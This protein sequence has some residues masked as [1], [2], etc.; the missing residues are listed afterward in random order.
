MRAR[1][2]VGTT[3]WAGRG[4]VATGWYPRDV[5]T[6]EERLHYYASQFPIVENEAG[7]YAI[8]TP[9][10]VALWADRTPD[11]F[12]MN[13][14]AHALFTAHYADPRR[15]PRDVVEALP[16]GVRAKPHV[17][18]R[19]LSVATMR[20]LER[21]FRD[22]L[23]PLHEAGK[24]GVVLFQFPMW[25]VISREHKAELSRLRESFAPYRVAV[26][27]RNKTWLSEE[28]RD[29]TLAHLRKEDIAYCCVDEVGPIPPIAAAT[30]DIA[31]VRMHGRNA[32]RF[33]GR[34]SLP[35]GARY[36]YTQAELREWVPRIRELAKHARE[37]HVL[38]NNA[39]ADYA[40]RGAHDLVEL[41]EGARGVT[42]AKAG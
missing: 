19:D 41:L 40:V 9:E 6:S 14:K 3:T 38:F 35:E 8:L 21:R 4:L 39:V 42:L 27:L 32:S 17:Y 30:A 23:L 7:Y 22:A 26:E 37:V 33:K 12:T 16:R 29:E 18:P 2:K 36:V 13:M 25:F 20:D 15:L 5:K 28:N 31:V 1:I 34:R 24:L 10:Q 11:G